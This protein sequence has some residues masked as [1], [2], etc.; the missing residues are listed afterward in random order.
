MQR[1]R[2]TLFPTLSRPCLHHMLVDYSIEYTYFIRGHAMSFLCLLLVTG[3]PHIYSAITRKSS[4]AWLGMQQQVTAQ[5]RAHPD[6]TCTQQ[7]W[8]GI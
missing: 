6:N 3:R 4:P 5:N 7:E 2:Y 8:M 1:K